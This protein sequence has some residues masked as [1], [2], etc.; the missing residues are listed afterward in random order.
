MER[1]DRGEDA[2]QVVRAF[3]EGLA[4]R[5]PS[6]EEVL[7]IRPQLEELQARLDR[8]R[9][10]GL[11]FRSVDLGDDVKALWAILRSKGGGLRRA[12]SFL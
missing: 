4:G 6:R 11:E 10:R 2:L 7:A 12:A 5:T 9:A 1:G 3:I 8:V